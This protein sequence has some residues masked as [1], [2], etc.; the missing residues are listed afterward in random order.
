MGGM[1]ARRQPE[2]KAPSKSGKRL[3][4]LGGTGFLGPAC[5]DAALAKGHTVTLFNRGITEKRKGGLYPDLEK[6]VGDRDPK[7]GEGLKAL[8][9]REW[10]AVIDTSAYVPRIAAASASLLAPRVAHYV[11]ISTI[12]VYKDN[13]VPHADETAEVGTIADPTVEEMGK[14][15]ENY[16]P[17][18]ALCEQAAEKAMPGRVTNVRPGFIIGPGDP[19]PRFPYWPA[20]LAAGG[21]VLVPGTPSDPVQ[22]VDVRDL[23]E[24]IIRLIESKT[25]GVF[26]AIGPEGGMTHQGFFEGIAKG[27][28]ASP[29]LAYASYESLEK[30]GIGFPICVPPGGETAGF[31]T[32]SASKAVKAGF[33]SRH[34]ADTAKATLAW[35]D[36]LEPAK[37]AALTS[38]VTR[39][40]EK[41][42][43]ESLKPGK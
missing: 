27:V 43:L 35:L 22:Y 29:E 28:G 32:R 31:H 42:F 8:E 1:A 15:F 14:Q 12:S 11:L 20:R 25:M 7:K 30:A 21:R 24:W 40:Q 19:T 5:V 17:L 4:I 9:G 16:G 10:D 18:K 3:L 39:D 2:P 36:G 23:G 37:R 6:L 33:T 38:A 26:N 41:A 13:A 34:I